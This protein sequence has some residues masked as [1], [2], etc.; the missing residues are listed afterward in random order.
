MSPMNSNFQI[1]EDGIR[2]TLDT[3]P[4]EAKKKLTADQVAW[5]T[6]ALDRFR[7]AIMLAQQNP[8]VSRSAQ[9]GRVSAIVE[10]MDIVG[11]EFEDKHAAANAV[12]NLAEFEILHEVDPSQQ[13]KPPLNTT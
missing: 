9:V 10:I 4:R 8:G 3:P 7:D 6:D 13:V 1:V 12:S 2:V 5:I 11:L